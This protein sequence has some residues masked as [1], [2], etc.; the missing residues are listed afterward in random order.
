ML[1]FLIRVGGE[2]KEFL[3]ILP[4][5]YGILNK[6]ELN[7]VHVIVDE[8]FAVN[9]KWFHDRLQI[10][11]IPEKKRDSLFGAHHFAAN[12]HEVF[13]IDFY[14]DFVCDFNSAFLGLAFRAR[15]KIGLQG[16]PKSY[17]YSYSLENFEGLFLDQ[18]KLSVIDVIDIFHKSDFPFMEYRELSREF[19]NVL[20]DLTSF[21]NKLIE[22]YRSIFNQFTD[23]KCFGWVPTH[24][25]EDF[26]SPFKDEDNIEV[27]EM[28]EEKLV[29]GLERFDLFITNSY[30]K[31]QVALLNGVRSFLIMEEGDELVSW[32]HMDSS[33]GTLKFDETDL[34]LYGFDEE[35]ALRVPGELED[36]II[37]FN[38]LR[39][40]PS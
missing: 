6:D 15:K 35:R 28:P 24:L 22:R 11:H 1:S 29:E 14:V 3:S 31:A 36:Y 9:D 20:F 37:N 16:G 40:E 39:L 19:E 13:N 4:L 27:F 5:V 38:T 30:I 2:E 33:V 12:L 8:G 18:K 7:R 34:V 32:A 25:S 17:L 10:Y 23:L 26:E 21:D